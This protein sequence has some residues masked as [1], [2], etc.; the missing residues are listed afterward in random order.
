MPTTI[1]ESAIETSFEYIHSRLPEEFKSVKLGIICGTGLG[2][3]V[4]T[5][6][7]ATKHEFHYGDIPGF[8]SSKG[9]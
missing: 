3:L 7:P 8:S 2:T 5:I 9:K 4:E 1:N 6:D